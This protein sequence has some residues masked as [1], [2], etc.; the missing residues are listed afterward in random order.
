MWDSLDS[1][2]LPKWYDDVKF[3]IFIHWGVYS[4]PAF[5]SEWFW[6]NWKGGK[7]K[8][9]DFMKKNYKPGFSYQDFARELTASRFDAKEWVKLFEES[10]AKYL[11]LT[12]KHHEGY[13]MWP[14]RYSFSWNSMDVGP[15]R[16]LVGELAE[17]TRRYSNLTFGLYHS[18]FEWYNPMYLNDKKNKFESREF[19]EKKVI[20]EMMELIN[21]YK[22]EV[23]WSDGDW[24]APDS[25]WKSTD[26]LAWLFNE[27]PVK[28]SIVVNDRWGIN[29]TCHHGSFY[30]CTD[31][32][33]PGVLVDHK[34]ENAMTTDKLSWGYRLEAS[35]EDYLSPDELIKELVTTVSCNGNLLLNVGPTKEGRILPVFEERLLEIG[36]WLKVNGEA[37]YS[38]RPWKFQNDSINSNVWYTKKGPNTVYAIVL[39][40]PEETNAV[41]LRDIA[42]CMTDS[43]RVTL[44]GYKSPIQVN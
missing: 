1:R 43:S 40:Y 29:T 31:R 39:D 22:P 24:E 4:V 38:T 23:L 44:L 5:G 30:T 20:P 8:Y 33:N 16:D 10:G 18:L 15:H 17:A 12:S 6:T 13:T 42:D 27:S 36:K 28:N 35:L 14:S 3:G 37:I 7:G 41:V 9:E 2:P 11:V 25:Y 34:W 21:K 32:Y 26:F 19:V